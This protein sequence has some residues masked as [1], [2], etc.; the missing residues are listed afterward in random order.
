LQSQEFK[1]PGRHAVANVE[2]QKRFNIKGRRSRRG[3]FV[4]L[5]VVSQTEQ[6][7][8]QTELVVPRSARRLMIPLLQAANDQALVNQIISEETD[9]WSQDLFKKV[10][11]RDSRAFGDEFDQLS[12]LSRNREERVKAVGGDLSHGESF[13]TYEEARDSWRMQEWFKFVAGTGCSCL[14][15]LT[16]SFIYEHHAV[17]LVARNPRLVQQCRQFDE[18]SVEIIQTVSNQIGI[19]PGVFPQKKRGTFRYLLRSYIRSY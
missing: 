14:Q 11:E 8:L 4:K 1:I 18:R 19:G 3:K 9:F 10:K 2:Q 17:C 12:K 16:T 13:A 5:N 7:S 15:P 6:R